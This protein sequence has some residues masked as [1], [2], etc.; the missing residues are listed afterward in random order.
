[1]EAILITILTATLPTVIVAGVAYWFTKKRE[2]E[3]E[4]HK[5]KFE[6]YKDYVIGLAGILEGEST[7]EDQITYA[8]VSNKLILVGS[9]PVL[10]ALIKFQGIIEN[11]S[12]DRSKADYD[13]S[14]TQLIY[15]IRKDIGMKDDKAS[16][17]ARLWNSGVPTDS[18]NKANQP[19]PKSGAADLRR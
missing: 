1:M 13:E 5:E 17:A 7:A 16:F 9:Q 19:T 3:A 4:L 14:L 8:L 15:E 6:H 18:P 2:R 11:K 10:D 12:D